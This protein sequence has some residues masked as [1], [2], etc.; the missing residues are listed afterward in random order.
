[1]A[2]LNPTY[3]GGEVLLAISRHLGPKRSHIIE[4][5]LH[6][7]REKYASL[8]IKALQIKTFVLVEL[9]RK[10]GLIKGQQL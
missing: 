4:R 10:P 1:M 9:S 7:S 8:F 6:D 5:L 3:F 2:D